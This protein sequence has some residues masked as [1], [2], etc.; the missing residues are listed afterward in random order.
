MALVKINRILARIG[1]DLFGI[2]NLKYGA[3]AGI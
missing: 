2:L 1:A 3:V